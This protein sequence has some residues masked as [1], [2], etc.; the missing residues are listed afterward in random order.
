MVHF[1]GTENDLILETNIKIYN[2]HN[3]LWFRHVAFLGLAKR[4][5]FGNI[6]K[7]FR[8]FDM[9]HFLARK[10]IWLSQN[11]K[12]II[13]K[14]FYDFDTSHFGGRKTI[15]FWQH[16]KIIMTKRF[17]A[18]GMAHF[19]GLAVKTPFSHFH[20]HTFTSLR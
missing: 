13:I 8:D 14:T 15:R 20:H 6:I 19:F 1:L 11:H 4:S 16:H 17:C 9:A 7:S 2:L 10:T 18:F 5:D 3:I 12:I